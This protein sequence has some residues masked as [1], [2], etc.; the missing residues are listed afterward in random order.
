MEKSFAVS[1][2]TIVRLKKDSWCGNEIGAVAICVEVWGN[3]NDLGASYIFKNG[4]SDGFKNTL[5]PHIL[6]VIGQ[7]VL[8]HIRNYQF[9][10]WDKLKEDYIDG[11]FH[12][13]FVVYDS[14]LSRGNTETPGMPYNDAVATITGIISKGKR[15]T[16]IRPHAQNPAFD[17]SL[18]EAFISIME[19]LQR[20][21][22]V[23]SLIE[24][25]AIETIRQVFK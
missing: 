21:K 10:N 22:T 19:E 3:K 23:D 16:K 9:T 4:R 13:T 18:A 15:A 25:R 2:G 20:C 14:K 1:V 24:N 8:D 5:A 12:D 11:K 17:P 6:E 7:S